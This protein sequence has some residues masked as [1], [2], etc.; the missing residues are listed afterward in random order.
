MRTL[1]LTFFCSLI[2]F[3]ISC[4]EEQTDIEKYYEGPWKI[5]TTDKDMDTTVT[6]T[7]N[8]EGQFEFNSPYSNDQVHVIGEVK[9]SGEVLGDVEFQENILGAMQGTL[10]QSGDG[11]GKYIIVN[12]TIN[13]TATKQ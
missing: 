2:V 12:K 8:A 13:W 10:S 5:S 11:S 9:G 3:A 4:K 1:K 7:V 6:M